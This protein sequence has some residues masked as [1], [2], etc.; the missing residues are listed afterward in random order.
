LL[1]HS[2]PS[3]NADRLGLLRELRK[4]RIV[5]FND[6]EGAG[7]MDMLLSVLRP[8]MSYV[9]DE[10]L[11]DALAVAG[12][13]SVLRSKRASERTPSAAAVADSADSALPIA[14]PSVGENGAAEN[15]QAVEPAQGRLL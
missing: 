6:G 13:T 7:S 14:A 2:L 9:S 10:A 15:A 3:P 11:E 4:H 5:R 1:A 12:Q 8:V